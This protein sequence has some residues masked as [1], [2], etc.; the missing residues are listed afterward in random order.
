MRDIS[1]SRNF[2]LFIIANDALSLRV[3]SLGL[4]FDLAYK[5]LQPFD[6]LIAKLLF[7][8]FIERD[9]YLHIC[10]QIEMIVEII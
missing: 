5:I 7:G 6:A 1:F 2:A 8:S 9:L 3:G 4:P 10:S